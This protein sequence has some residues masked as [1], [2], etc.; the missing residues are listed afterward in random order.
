MGTAAQQDGSP[1]L[2]EC[3]ASNYTVSELG[4]K[5][6]TS[7]LCM[8]S[9]RNTH[10]QQNHGQ[11]QKTGREGAGEGKSWPPQVLVPSLDN[12]ILLSPC[13]GGFPV[14]ESRSHK[15][16]WASRGQGFGRQDLERP[17]KVNLRACPN[18]S[19]HT[20]KIMPKSIPMNPGTFHTF[21]S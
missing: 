6:S 3:L 4:H 21:L 12:L 1:L 20:L 17:K 16:S 13:R 18:Q 9:Q 8:Q 14:A 15:A 11:G 19:T 5:I 2:T 10:I 7:V